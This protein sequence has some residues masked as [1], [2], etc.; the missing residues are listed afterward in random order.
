MSERYQRLEEIGKGGVGTVYK[1]IHTP[2][3]RPVAIKEIKDI[4]NLFGD[5]QKDDIIQKF[6]AA[7]QAHA[8]LVH[9]NIVQIL[10]IDV[11]QQYPF[12]VMEL[13]N[14]GS[15]RQRITERSMDLSQKLS[16]FVDVARALQY[17]HAQGVIHRDLKPENI[18]FGTDSSAKVVDFSI[19][20]LMDRD[21]SRQQIYIGVGTVAYLAPEQFRNPQDAN[22]RSDIYSLGIIFYE[23]LTGKL[24]GRRSPMPSSFYP[25]IPSKLDDVF[26]NMC[27]DAEEDRYQS[28]EEMLRDLLSDPEVNALLMGAHAQVQVPVQEVTPMAAAPMAAAPM[29]APA[30]ASVPMPPSEPTPAPEPMMAMVEE[31]EEVFEEE[32]VQ[33]EEPEEEMPALVEAAQE[34]QGDDNDILAKLN[35]YS[36]SF[37]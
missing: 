28:I 29:A 37:T 15:L 2:L 10:D 6:E 11:D 14:G 13:A 21:M 26:D 18:L 1:G 12:F 33:E 5:L 23:I 7:V 36:S 3:Q 20:S 32:P 16:C 30:P 34:D 8:K 4:F 22:E 35:K 31:E 9:A 19:N 17:A 25:E 24:P 27:M